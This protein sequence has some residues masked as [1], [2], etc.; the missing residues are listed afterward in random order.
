MT[1]IANNTDKLLSFIADKYQNKGELDNSS[2]VQ[3]I[4]LCS[5]FLNLKTLSNYS[6][7]NKISYNGAKKCRKHIKIDNVKFIIN[8]E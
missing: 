6:K 5:M 2:L 4:E 3:I 1:R 8:N 7:E